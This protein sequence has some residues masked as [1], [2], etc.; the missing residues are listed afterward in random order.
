MGHAFWFSVPT[1]VINGLGGIQY[2]TRLKAYVLVLG[3]TAINNFLFS[4][5][6]LFHVEPVGSA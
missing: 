1:T 6:R 2:A 5:M 4:T 3:V